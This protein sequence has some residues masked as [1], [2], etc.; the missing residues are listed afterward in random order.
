MEIDKTRKLTGFK[1]KPKD[2]VSIPDRED[3]ALISGGMYMFTAPAM[4]DALNLDMTIKSSKHDFGKNVI[5]RMLRKKKQIYVHLFQDEQGAPKHWCDIG[6]PDAYFE[7]NMD[8][9]SVNPKFNLHNPDWPWRTLNTSTFPFKIVFHLECR[10]SIISDGCIFDD[11]RLY[12]A[13]IGS[14]V[15]IGSNVDVSDAVIMD[16]VEIKNNVRIHRA[17]I[18]KGNII[19]EGSVIDANCMNY[20]GEYEIT[21]SGV[22]IIARNYEPWT[23]E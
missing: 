14:G 15:R 5:P 11:C 12:H 6:L 1:E 16:D 18:D 23:G 21:E 20:D 8:L 17:I 19:P 4:V 2:P 3:E 7:A 22:V 13:V 10:S 9:V